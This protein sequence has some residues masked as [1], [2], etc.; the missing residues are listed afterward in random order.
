MKDGDGAHVRLF[1][2]ALRLS[3]IGASVRLPVRPLPRPNG[4]LELGSRRTLGLAPRKCPLCCINV[5]YEN[6]DA[7]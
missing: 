5:Y 6:V 7:E 2:Q 1:I 3:A 4:P